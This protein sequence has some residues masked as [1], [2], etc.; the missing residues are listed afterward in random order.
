MVK[1]RK[2]S[3]ELRKSLS[4]SSEEDLREI[5]AAIIRAADKL[6]RAYCF[7]FVVH[8]FKPKQDTIIF[9]SLNPAFVR[10]LLMAAYPDYDFTDQEND[11]LQVLL[12]KHT[13]YDL[14]SIKKFKF[15]EFA[16]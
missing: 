4:E 15:H 16:D 10:N 5:A 14:L 3:E 6:G 7:A 8:D 2:A 11:E 1:A 12:F 9:P 13:L